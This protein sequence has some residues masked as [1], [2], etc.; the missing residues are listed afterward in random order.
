LARATAFV[1][2]DAQNGELANDV[3]EDDGAIA[4]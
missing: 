2:L 3:A 1:A 4:G